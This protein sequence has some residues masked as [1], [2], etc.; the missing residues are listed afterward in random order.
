MRNV[1]KLDKEHSLIC[2]FSKFFELWVT[3]DLSVQLF[4]QEFRHAKAKN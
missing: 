2:S 3:F 4:I 1:Q